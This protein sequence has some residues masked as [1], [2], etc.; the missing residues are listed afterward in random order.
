MDSVELG[1]KKCTGLQL[2]AHA[3]MVTGD[4]ACKFANQVLCE[5][6]HLNMG[7]WTICKSADIW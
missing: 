7:L 4:A 6:I 3:C 1:I 5:Y 2:L